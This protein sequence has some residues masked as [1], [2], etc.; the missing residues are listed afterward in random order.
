MKRSLLAVGK[1]TSLRGTAKLVCVFVFLSGIVM[2][3]VLLYLVSTSPEFGVG[4][5]WNLWNHHKIPALSMS[6]P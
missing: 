2:P 5:E 6:H 4:S 1:M 3:L